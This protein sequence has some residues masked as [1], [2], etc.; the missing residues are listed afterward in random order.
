MKKDKKT[1][2]IVE[3]K[4][5][6]SKP[7]KPCHTVEYG[8]ELGQRLLGVL[9][10]SGT[11]VGLAANQVGIDARVCVIDVEKPIILVNPKI[12]S[13]FGRIYFREGCL[14]FPDEVVLTERYANIAVNA[15]NHSTTLFFKAQNN[16]LECVCVQHEIDHLD[17]ITM[18][19]RIPADYY[20]INKTKN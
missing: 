12:I 18:Y 11:G 6:I 3:G 14:S 4:K 1:L 19:D 7:C 20:E 13:K 2:R 5:K 16:V 10:E 15:D 9:A 8:E 17:G